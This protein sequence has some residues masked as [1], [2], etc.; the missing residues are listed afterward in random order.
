MNMNEKREW[1]ALQIAVSD[2]NRYNQETE[3]KESSNRYYDLL[4]KQKESDLIFGV[5]IV[6]S[7][8][9]RTQAFSQYVESLREHSGEI[10]VPIMLM[11]VNEAAEEVK[12]GIMFSWF[13]QRPLITQNVLMRKSTQDNWNTILNSLSISSQ[14]GPIQFLQ[15]DKFYIKKMLS[16]SVQRGDGYRY[17]AELVYLRKLSA[18]YRMN[19]RERNSQKEIFDFY[20]NGYSPDEYPS[21]SLDEAIYC[22]VNEGIEIQHAHNQLIVM[23]AQLGDLQLYRGFY[24]GQVHILLSPMIDNANDLASQMLGRFSTLNIDVELYARSEEDRNYFNEWTFSYL[25]RVEGWVT[26]VVE[27][28]NALQNYKKLSEVIG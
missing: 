10:P 26:K 27:Y 3:I 9:S 19:A 17:D 13:R 18:V 15:P 11:S 20:L 1:R 8:F 2:I 12:I 24:R 4:V 28:R 7:E 21:D 14:E 22:A 23:N 6:R 5:E 16:L 25:D